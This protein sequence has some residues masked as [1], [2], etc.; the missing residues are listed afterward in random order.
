M[1]EFRTKDVITEAKQVLSDASYSPKKL[2]LLHTGVAAAAGLVLTLL[3]YFLDA[4]IGNTGGL[5]GM[6]NRA[7]LE[8]VQYVLELAV[9][10]LSPFWAL[11]FVAAAL[12]WSRRE[13]ATGGTLVKGLRR[14]GPALR[15][16]LLQGLIYFVLAMVAVQIG[17][18][19]YTMTPASNTLRALVEELSEAELTDT[20]ALMTLLESLDGDVL[21]NVMLTMLPFLLIP[22]VVLIVPVAYRMRLAPYILMD[23]PRCGALFAITL[24]FRMTK[25]NC[26]KLL[27]LDL[28]YWW[29]YLLEVL[30]TTLAFGDVLL[31]LL[32][33][34]LNMNAETVA[35]MCYLL[36]LV[37]QLALYA[38]K[39]PQVFTS[40]AVFYDS[41]Q[42]QVQ[43]E[44][45]A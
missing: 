10:V 3:T 2:A 43:T 5:S 24:S 21:L 16:Y 25:G 35:M 12:H 29:Y 41:L 39:K 13:T 37:A 1:S 45:Q 20:D 34:S 9:T 28:R 44:T 23:E 36:T 11:G 4:G 42:P 33:V 38:W 17:S 6:G 40:Y 30:V 27:R 32:G 19:L 22:V 31:P 15:M 8:T 18:L 7:L 26:L 14:W